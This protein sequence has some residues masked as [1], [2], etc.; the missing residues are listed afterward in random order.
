M[1]PRRVDAV[2]FVHTG[3]DAEAL[4]RHL[5]GVLA[6]PV[7]D[8]FQPEWVAVPSVGMRRWLSLQLAG[9][10]GAAP[11]RTDG[12]AANIEWA[13][14]GSLRNAVLDADPAAAELE[15]WRVPR[16]VWA[17]LD[18]IAAQRKGRLAFLA[19]P[20]PGG[21]RYSTARRIADLFDRYHVHRPEMVRQW[22]VGNFV[23]AAGRPLADHQRWQPLLWQMVEERIGVESPADRLPKLLRQVTDGEIDPLLP[24]RLALFG[25]G[26]LPGGASFLELADALGGRRDVYLYLLEP[27][28]SLAASVRSADRP[29][30]RLRAD[31]RSADLVAHPLLRSWGRLSRETSV[32]LGQAGA[33][34][35][36]LTS[37]GG[38]DV[39]TDRLADDGSLLGRLQGA[40]RANRPPDPFLVPAPDDASVQFHACH[41]ATRQVEVLRDALL[42]ALADPELDLTEDDVVVLCPDLER[43][44]PLLEAVFGPSADQ[45]AAHEGGA[46]ALRYR[47]ADRSLRAANPVL[48]AT[49]A[50]LDLVAGRFDAPSVLDFIALPPV[51]HRFRF[52][53]DDLARIDDW[54][55]AAAVRWGLDGEHREGWAVPAQLVANTWRAGLDRLLVGS[56]V[57]TS[58][59]DLVVGDVVPLASWG[60]EVDLAGR[61]AEL[62]AR[63]ADLVEAS[64]SPRPVAEWLRVVADAADALFSVPPAEVRQTESL[65]A[66]LSQLV[67][68][69]QVVG[70]ASAVELD[71]VDLRR[72]LADHLRTAPGRPDFFRGGITVTSLTPLRWIPFRVVALLGMDQAALGSGSVDGDD[73]V[74]LDQEVGDRDVR[75]DSRHALLEAVLCARERLIVVRDGHD[76]RTN[77]EVPAPVAVMELRDAVLAEVH[78]D[79]AETWSKRLERSHPRQ[80]FDDGCFTPGRLGAGPWSFDRLALAAAE[81]RAARTSTTLPPF[82][83]RPLPPLDCRRIDL[84]DLHAYLKHPTREFL[85]QRLGVR[86][87]KVEDAVAPVLPIVMGG[88]DR[89][90][91]GTDLLAHLFDGVDEATW[92]DVER[93]VGNFP[94]GVLGEVERDAVATDARALAQV[95]RRL[96][97][98]PGPGDLVPVAVT[99]DDGTRLVGSVVD[100]VGHDALGVGVRGPLR[101]TYSKTKAEQHLA[102]WLDLLVLVAARPEVEWR[103]VSVARSAKPGTAPEVLVL[104]PP[105]G[106]GADAAER[107]RLARDGLA[108]A[109][110]CYRRGMCEPVPLFPQVSRAVHLGDGARK[111]WGDMF[112]D[113]ADVSHQLVFGLVDF[114]DLAAL[115]REAHDPPGPSTRLA[116]FARHLWDAVGRSAPLLAPELLEKVLAADE[117]PA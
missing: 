110:D 37:V 90:K 82:L 72:L 80:A 53:E 46:P 35:W 45:R 66:T 28:P 63:L 85:R 22:K 88:L 73:L 87:P 91:V 33:A 13:F 10:L 59:L 61:L 47:I 9:H 70:Q 43:F 77:Q 41:G 44:A 50:L 21:S 27:S 52:T 12:V 65:H 106:D 68:H 89:W 92:A 103:S 58:G 97:V 32:L 55:E 42:H 93:R 79:H 67:E 38:D 98:R 34:Q 26:V 29:R 111:A 19:T 62:V 51:R 30:T 109:V 1:V 76:V 84:A 17:V 96:G 99:L 104:L 40:L 18:V 4:A 5:A 78:P 8:P 71:F 15:A 102:A 107:A 24:E 105:G 113:Q 39:P 112:G 69:S 6:E 114:D 16:L 60:D 75:A 101:V 74:A 2:M 36:D 117:V 11:G 54:V 81:A 64:T 23:D 25:L 83:S 20:P 95:C 31:D 56:T 7:A 86:V 108:V 3:H 14:P 116:C 100:R 49:A 57:H 94:P 115:P 48:E